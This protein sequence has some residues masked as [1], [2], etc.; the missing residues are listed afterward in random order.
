MVVEMVGIEM[1]LEVEDK[2]LNNLRFH[3]A[4]RIV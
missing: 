3:H 2:Y 4:R 1:T